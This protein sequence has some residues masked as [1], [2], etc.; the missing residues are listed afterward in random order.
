MRTCVNKRGHHQPWGT[1]QRVM[2]SIIILRSALVRPL[3]FARHI[4]LNNLPSTPQCCCCCCY[5][6][7]YYGIAAAVATIVGSTEIYVRTGST[8]SL[9]CVIQGSGAIPPRIL[10]WFHDSRPSMIII[11]LTRYL[12]KPSTRFIFKK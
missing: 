5:Y 6:Y 1:A 9:T 7:H 11:N 2:Y 10:F 12:F 4:I 8:I 3:L